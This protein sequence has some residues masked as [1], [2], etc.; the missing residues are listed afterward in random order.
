MNH[1]K[2][3]SFINRFIKKHERSV[4]FESFCAKVHPVNCC[5][6]TT[7]EHFK[8]QVK[9]PFVKFDNNYS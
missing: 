9:K 6:F 3:V 2:H 1:I 4:K 5:N 8:K 7:Y